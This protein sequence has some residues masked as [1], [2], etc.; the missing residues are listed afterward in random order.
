MT[1]VSAVH[2]FFDVP[3]GFS[4][5]SLALMLEANT[6]KSEL[7][8]GEVAVYINR[9]F[10][11]VKVMTGQ[12]IAYWRGPG[13]GTVTPEVIKVLPTAFGAPRLTF[14]KNLENAILK[15]FETEFGTVLKRL[16]VANA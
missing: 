1:A 9:S 8:K 7:P 14:A 10:S 5:K 3:M 4:H 11:A 6:K 15:T 16:K 12:T 13:P 2:V